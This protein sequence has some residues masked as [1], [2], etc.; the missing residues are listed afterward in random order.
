MSKQSD[1][2]S[3]M[4]NANKGTAGTNKTYAQNQG[5]RGAQLNTQSTSKGSNKK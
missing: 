4:V 5:N 3:N 2:N 1:H